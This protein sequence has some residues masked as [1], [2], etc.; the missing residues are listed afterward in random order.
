MRGGEDKGELWRGEFKHDI[1]TIIAR[2]FV[3]VTK[4]LH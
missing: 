4:Y 1:C 3:K 2:S